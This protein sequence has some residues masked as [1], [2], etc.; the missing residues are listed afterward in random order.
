MNVRRRETF[1]RL[2]RIL[3]RRRILDLRQ[4]ARLEIIHRPLRRGRI[5]IH[6]VTD[7]DDPV[8]RL[9]VVGVAHRQAGTFIIRNPQHRQSATRIVAHNLRVHFHTV[10]D[11]P[12]GFVFAQD[13]R[14]GQQPSPGHR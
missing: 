8:A 7:Q 5:K 1:H 13:G 2:D 6:R 3:A 4:V 11:H 9:Q 12:R 10:D 14:G